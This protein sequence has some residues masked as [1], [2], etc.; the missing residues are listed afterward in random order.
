MR[1]PVVDWALSTGRIEFLMSQPIDGP[2]PDGV[3]PST[4]RRQ[5]VQDL[6]EAA[7]GRGPSDAKVCF[8]VAPIGKEGSDQR[9][10]SDQVLKYV[11]RPVVEEKDYRALRADEIADPG[12]ITQQVVD[13]LLNAKL[14]IAD[15]TGANPNVYYELAVRHGARKHFIQLIDS[16]ETL[17]FDV[18]DQRT[19]SFDYRDLDSVHVAKQRLGGQLE[20]IE[21]GDL[22]VSTPLTFS[23]DLQA[24][25]GSNDPVEQSH[26]EIMEMLNGIMS[27][28]ARTY[29]AL[30]REHP[31][32]AGAPSADYQALR[33]VIE[34]LVE[35]GGLSIE[36][37]ASLKTS[38]TSSSHDNWVDSLMERLTLR[39]HT[40][41]ADDIPF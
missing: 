38:L 27:I 30:R 12:L 2:M 41:A 5:S 4:V 24:L 1:L 35:D 6:G 29:N 39:W 33:A 18:A 34:V 10:R 22:E 20:A 16:N 13:H 40:R 11:I 37:V 9:R 17:P 25:R 19:I 21:R 7:Q 36:Q 14:V 26:A 31:V 23:L 28:N 32:R 3:R 15:L 8:V